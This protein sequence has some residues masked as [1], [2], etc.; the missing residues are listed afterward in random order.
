MRSAVTNIRTIMAPPFFTAGFVA[1]FAGLIIGRI[2]GEKALRHLTSDEK[3]ALVDG[4][5]RLRMYGWLPLLLIMACFVALLFSPH[6]WR[7][8]GFVALFAALLGLIAWKHFYV[9]RRL[10]QLSVSEAYC[11]T[12]TLA[13]FV[14]LLGFLIFFVCVA[15][16]MMR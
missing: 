13:Q 15:I 11:R 7:V 5:S 2:L 12:I 3:L 16:T 9:R 14:S 10:R 6:E 8:P 4:F 1:M